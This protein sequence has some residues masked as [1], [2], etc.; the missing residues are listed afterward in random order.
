MKVVAEECRTQDVQKDTTHQ[1]VFPFD[2]VSSTK[3]R[4]EFGVFH[5]CGLSEGVCQVRSFDGANV[6]DAMLM[7]ANVKDIALDK[8][9]CSSSEG[10]HRAFNSSKKGMSIGNALSIIT[11]QSGFVSSMKAS[12]SGVNFSFTRDSALK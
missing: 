3:G 5:Q 4:D 1:T 2:V 7:G 9:H 8:R 12:I 11:I 6:D 10:I